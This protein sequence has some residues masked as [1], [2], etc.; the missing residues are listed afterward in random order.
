MKERVV[1]FALALAAFALFYTLM[2]PKPSAPQE[3]VT[4][5][6]SIEAGPNGHAALFRW[7]EAERVPVA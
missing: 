4:R 1:T 6:I 2:A 7:L 3:R 5:P